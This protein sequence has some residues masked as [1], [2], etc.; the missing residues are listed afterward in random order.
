[1]R[2]Y[3]RLS[4][5]PRSAS[6]HDRYRGSP[7]PS[8]RLDHFNSVVLLR[9][10]PSHSRVILWWSAGGIQSVA[11][12]GIHSS[13]LADRLARR[14]TPPTGVPFFLAVYPAGA[15]GLRNQAIVGADVEALEGVV[16]VQ[17][18]EAGDERAA[19]HARGQDAHQGAL[20][21]H[22][23][24]RIPPVKVWVLRPGMFK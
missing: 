2:G 12:A 23:V 15:R 22:V 4:R 10:T 13:L 16:P 20:H 8:R 19:P 24:P 18:A 21:L 11:A 1:M 3:T 7:S 5:A 17:V 14:P 9:R 6:P